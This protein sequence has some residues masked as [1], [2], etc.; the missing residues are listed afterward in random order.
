MDRH[1]NNFSKLGV[2]LLKDGK[3]VFNGETLTQAMVDYPEDVTKFFAN[4]E[5]GFK[6]ITHRITKLIDTYNGADGLIQTK[7]DSYKKSIDKLHVQADHI[8]KRLGSKETILRKQY[9]RLEKYMGEMKQTTA[10]LQQQL[11]SLPGVA[12]KNGG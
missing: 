10:Q 5:Q 2:E 1:V 3:L 11:K 9:E 4:R 12:S 8:Q 7:S 6:G